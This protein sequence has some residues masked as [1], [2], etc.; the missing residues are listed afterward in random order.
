MIYNE[1]LN[2]DENET[3]VVHG[4]DVFEVDYTYI[5]LGCV[6][7]GN[8]GLSNWCCSW[9]HESDLWFLNVIL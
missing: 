7:W 1:N 5:V 9:P 4:F 8:G 2:E 6:R 3:S